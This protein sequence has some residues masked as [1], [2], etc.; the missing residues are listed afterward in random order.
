[1]TTYSQH[2]EVQVTTELRD[3]VERVRSGVEPVII[4]TET[5]GEPLAAIVS[6]ATLALL[7]A[8]DVSQ[9][10]DAALEESDTEGLRRR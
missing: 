7:D 5:G 1:M 8:R 10:S 9:R 4:L 2:P 6:L 3:A